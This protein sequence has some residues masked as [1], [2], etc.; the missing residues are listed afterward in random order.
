VTYS[1]TAAGSWAQLAIEWY[2]HELGADSQEA[3]GMKDFILQ[4]ELHSAWG[5]REKILSVGVPSI[6][7]K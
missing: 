2:A 6:L 5:T 4:P 3:V 1:A 7:L